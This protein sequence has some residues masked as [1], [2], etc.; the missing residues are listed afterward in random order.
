MIVTV[1][2]IA[3]DADAAD[4]IRAAAATRNKTGNRRVKGLI[5]SSL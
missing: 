1:D 3:A 2:L 5:S 4:N